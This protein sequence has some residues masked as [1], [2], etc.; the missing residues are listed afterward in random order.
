MLERMYVKYCE[1]KGFKV[2]ILEQSEGEVAGIKTATLKVNGDYAYGHLR[3]ETGIHRL[4]RKSPFDSNARRHTSFASVFV[5]PEVD[6][7]IEIDRGGWIAARA[8]G[9]KMLPYGATWWKMPV[10]AHSSPIYLDMP[11]RPPEAAES[12]RLLLDQLGY[13]ERWVEKAANFPTPE[14]RKEA[15]SYVAQAK[16]IY[17]KVAK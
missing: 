2:E 3:T 4:V 8:H 16:A 14:N 12:A 15:R 5:Y 13:F 7:T 6:D 1:R 10:F 9:P 11:G 17:N